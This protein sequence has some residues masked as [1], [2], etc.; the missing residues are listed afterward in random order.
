MSDYKYYIINQYGRFGFDDEKVINNSLIFKYLKEDFANVYDFN[1][2]DEFNRNDIIKYI[3]IVNQSD[4]NNYL[5]EN[6]LT[7]NF[8]KFI[9]YLGADRI[10][11]KII[12]YIYEYNIDLN[13]L[14]TNELHYILRV[15]IFEKCKPNQIP[16]QFL[17]DAYFM[18]KWDKNNVD[19]IFKDNI[20][21]Y[22]FPYEGNNDL[23]ISLNNNDR[24]LLYIEYNNSLAN[25]YTHIGGTY[26]NALFLYNNLK[27]NMDLELKNK[28]Y[29]KLFKK[30]PIFTDLDFK[31]TYNYDTIKG[32]FLQTTEEGM[33]SLIFFYVPHDYV[34]EIEY[35]IIKISKKND[36]YKIHISG[37]KYNY[38]GTELEKWNFIKN[39]LIFDKKNTL[40]IQEIKNYFMNKS[41]F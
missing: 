23:I 4:V 12:N 35:E 29:I 30:E 13:D 36:E 5:N 37:E 25:E 38:K 1:I 11:N 15:K 14:F 41:L 33:S 32:N 17:Y 34:E 21:N 24:N 27:N 26:Y 28:L 9:D 39:K 8:I 16:N 40:R 6:N 7:I 18:A 3:E 2:S 10:M 19:G 31:N 20:N 22:I